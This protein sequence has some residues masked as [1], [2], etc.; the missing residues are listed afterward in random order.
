MEAAVLTRKIVVFFLIVGIVPALI[1]SVY[2][3]IN[4]ISV[5]QTNIGSTREVALRNTLSR[6]DHAIDSL[7]EFTDW[8]FL[9][10]DINELLTSTP[11]RLENYQERVVNTAD[12]IAYHISYSQVG[13]LLSTM[14]LF[15]NNGVDFRFG[16]TSPAYVVDREELLGADWMEDTELAFGRLQWGPPI[17]PIHEMFE[18]RYLVPMVRSIL[19]IDSARTLGTL[20]GFVNERI[21]DEIYDDYGLTQGELLLFVY[22]TGLIMSSNS[23]ELI[24]VSIDDLEDVPGLEEVPGWLRE[25]TAGYGRNEQHMIASVQSERYNWRLVNVIPAAE[26]M[27]EQRKV[28]LVMLGVFGLSIFLTG[29][30]SAFLTRNINRPIHALIKKVEGIPLDYASPPAPARYK[31]EIGLLERSVDTMSA[32]IGQLMND[33]IAEE[34][35]RHEIELRLLQSQINPHFLYNTLSVIKWMAMLQG[36][37]AIGSMVTAMS[38]VF[39]YAIGKTSQQ[40]SLREELDV[41]DEY[42][43]IHQLAGKHTIEFHRHVEDPALLDAQVVKFILQPIVENALIHG[44]KPKQSG[45]RIDL[46]VA[47]DDDKLRISIR[48]NGI[49]IPEEQLV[50]LS[51]QHAE[52]IVEPS[53]H[54]G[55]TNIRRRIQLLYGSAGDGPRD[56]PYGLEVDS[57]FGKYTE[58]TIT[59]P[60]K[61]EDG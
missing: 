60:L 49:G 23:E 45:G 61:P 47:S 34:R 1:V 10:N 31:N 32:K 11:G 12:N 6:F 59:L 51:S 16:N 43:R 18:D 22:P 8:V 26:I 9:D 19:D 3:G 21:F 48:D 25:Q 5:L 4:T 36:A 15:G 14:F 55:L 41:L 58:V 40:V 7:V 20:I 46:V 50:T 37:D 39:K 33:K 13:D 35:E 42:M 44:L 2:H 24:G 53:G 54:V 27:R 30:I 57:E 28:T 29:I 56:E 38:K 17:P 52:H